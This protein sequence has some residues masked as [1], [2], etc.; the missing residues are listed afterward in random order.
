MGFQ[1]GVDHYL[2]W[3][4]KAEAVLRNYFLDTAL[5]TGLRGETYWRIHT[6]TESSP[7]W[8]A[9][10]RDEMR[11]RANELEALEARVLAFIARLDMAP[12]VF[13]VLDTHVLLHYEPPAQVRWSEVVGQRE[14]RLVL[15]LRVIEELDEKKYTARADLADR[16]RRLLSHLRTLLAPTAGLPVALAEGVSIEVPVDDGPRHRPLDAD[17]EILETALGLKATG[18]P[19]LLITGDAGLAIRA[20]RES[21]ETVPMPDK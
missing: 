7:R 4:D 11:R 18:R 12:G 10:V 8:A 21:L 15:P 17:Y 19:V 16:T 3:V 6:M 13:A 14:V 9:I 5:W 2:I 20:A 1:A